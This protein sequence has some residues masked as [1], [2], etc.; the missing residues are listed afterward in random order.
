ME[1]SRRHFVAALVC[2]SAGVA[3]AADRESGPS[4]P[5]KPVFVIATIEVKPGQRAAFIEIFKANVPNVLAE[6]GC[7]GYEPVVDLET[8]IANQPPLR[9]NVMT[10][11]E[12]WASLDALRAHLKAPHMDA[13][14]AQ[15]KDLV[16]GATLHIMRPA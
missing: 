14:R 7:I 8:G 9:D 15:V 6:D 4:G 5:D 2:S 16:A 12:K 13:Y 11:V 10:V 1:C 3:F